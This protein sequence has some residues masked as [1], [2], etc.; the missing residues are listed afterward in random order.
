MSVLPCFKGVMN[1]LYDEVYDDIGMQSLS[2][3]VHLARD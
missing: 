1:C 3:R 2:V